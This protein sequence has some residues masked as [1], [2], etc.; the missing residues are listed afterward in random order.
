MECFERCKW[1]VLLP[2]RCRE[3]YEREEVSAVEIAA[4]CE[5][6]LFDNK[7]MTCYWCGSCVAWYSGGNMANQAHLRILAQGVHV[8][9][10]WRH[11]KVSISPDLSKAHLTNRNLTGVNFSHTNLNGA[12]FTHTNMAGAN[13]FDASLEKT[14]GLV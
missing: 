6:L 9:N 5:V 11:N 8:W 1:R 2:S 4:V 14:I 12:D 7:G 13:L 3:L 10:S